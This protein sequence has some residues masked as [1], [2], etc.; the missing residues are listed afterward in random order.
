MILIA[1]VRIDV[2]EDDN[3][4]EGLEDLLDNVGETHD[5]VRVNDIKSYGIAPFLLYRI[6]FYYFKC[7]YDVSPLVVTPCVSRKGWR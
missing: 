6:Q 4:I 7:F 2:L 3:Y 5:D 1:R